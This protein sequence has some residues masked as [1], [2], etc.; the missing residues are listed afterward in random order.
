MIREFYV[1]LY[2][3]EVFTEADTTLWNFP[4]YLT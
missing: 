2:M 3:A 4:C 1:S